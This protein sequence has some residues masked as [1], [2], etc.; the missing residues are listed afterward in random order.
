M[1]VMKGASVLEYKDTNGFTV[2]PLLVTDS[3]SSWNRI[4]PLNEDSLDLDVSRLPD[5][6]HG[7][8][9]TSLLMK[10]LIGNRQQRIIVSSDADYLSNDRIEFHP[11]TYNQEFAFWTFSYFTYGQFPANTLHPEDIDTGFYVTSDD[12]PIQEILLYYIVPGIILLL[13]TIILIR[14]KRK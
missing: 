1:V 9:F 6:Q 10:R 8:F 11:P 7:R 5:D 12:M 13:G 2:E 4:E 14:R 3:I